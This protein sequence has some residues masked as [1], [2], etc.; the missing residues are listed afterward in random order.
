MGLHVGFDR[1]S[2]DFKIPT[3]AETREAVCLRLSHLRGKEVDRSPTGP[4]AEV[5]DLVTTFVDLNMNLAVEALVCAMS[6]GPRRGRGEG[7]AT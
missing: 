4:D 5:I 7:E 6:R 3:Y 2:G 1:H